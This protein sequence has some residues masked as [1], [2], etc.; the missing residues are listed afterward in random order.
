MPV[1]PIFIIVA[2][3]AVFIIILVIKGFKIVPQAETMV[4]ERL[5]RY[6]RTLESGINIIW[7]I[8]EKPRRMEWR[9]TKADAQGN[10][11]IVAR[12]TYRIDLRETVFDFP[13]Q[14]VITKDNVALQIDALIYFQIVDPK[15]AVYEVANLPEAI[16]KLTK[17]TLRNVLGEL[18]L[19]ESLASRDTINT[20]LT[21]IL[22]QSTDKWGVKV[23]RVEL[24]DILPPK[25]IRQAM[26]KQMRAERDRRAS[27]LEAEGE[28]QSAI[29]RAEGEKQAAIRS[30]EGEAEARMK[31]AEGEAE[32]IR[33]VTASVAS[34]GGDPVN[35]LIAIRY[36]DALVNMFEGSSSK[37]VYMPYEA[38]GLLSSIGGIKD[39]LVKPPTQG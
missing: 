21:T 35:Y 30:A 13:R 23:T 37:V 8:V 10:K 4:I 34:S 12:E 11:L 3:I 19:D 6:N 16:E 36:I 15:R 20:R 17:T 18:D 28:K 27:I 22:D 38:A 33:R 14:N 24:Q 9:F 5:G 32:A 7:P 31:I 1:E 25:D 26:E 29:L 2:A 39:M